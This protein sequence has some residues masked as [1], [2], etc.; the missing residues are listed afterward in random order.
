MVAMGGD[1][2]R[3]AILAPVPDHP[4]P[5][6]WLANLQHLERAYLESGDPIRG[7][8]FSGG[9]QRWRAERSPILEAIG[10][11]GDIIDVGCANGYLL[12]CLV[13]WAHERGITLTPHGLDIGPGLVEAARARLPGASIHLGNAWDWTPPRRYRYVYALADLVPVDRLDPMVDRL[14]AEFVEPGGR[15]IVGD[16]GSR[17]RR[18]TPRS[19]AAILRA[20]GLVAGETAGGDPPVTR[21]AWIDAPTRPRPS[22]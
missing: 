5:P 3:G 19:V 10:T 16:Y 12:E 17:S 2:S 1:A 11:D 20:H 22:H 14:L 8:G 7:S 9:P 13:G 15:L 6:E 18:I 21:F 4:L